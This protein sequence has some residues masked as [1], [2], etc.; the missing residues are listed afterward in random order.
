[1][2]FPL[3]EWAERF[4]ATPSVSRDGNLEIAER[5]AELLASVGLAHRVDEV[6][7]DGVRHRNVIAD[8][9]PEPGGRDG[10]LLVTHLDT[11][12]PGEPAATPTTRGATRS[13]QL[14]SKPIPT[15]SGSSAMASRCLSGLGRYAACP[16]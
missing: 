13:C 8:L 2:P 14:S 9:G 6:E 5:A 11:V 3:L 1:M 7:I 15:A 4:I 10:V 16:S 12:P